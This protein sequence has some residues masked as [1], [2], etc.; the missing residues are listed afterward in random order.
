M[1]G[2]VF[3]CSFSGLN[4]KT[5]EVQADISAGLPSFKVVGL[6]DTSVQESKERV[7]T[8]IKNSGARF[9]QTRKTINLAP[10]QL[11]KQGSHFDLPMATALLLADNQIS[12]QNIT[13]SIV[14]GEL[15]LTG[16]VK[17]ISGALPITQ[18]AKEKGFTKIFLPK[19]NAE[20][21][22]FIE[23]IEIY[24]LETFKQL[25]EYALG[26]KDLK[27]IPHS[28]ITHSRTHRFSL[29]TNI[30]GLE[31]AKRGLLIAAAGGH[32]TLLHGSPGCGKTVICRAFRS[33]LTQMTKKEVLETTTIFSIGG[34]L[35]SE[36][37]I[38]K[39]RSFREVHHTAT[40]S[41][42]I[43]GGAKPRPGEIS[44]AHNG[45]LFLDEI[46]EFPKQILEALRQPLEDKH[47]NINRI[48]SSLKFPS[49]FILIATMN[50]CAC[51]YKGD[52][53]IPCICSEAH[54]KRYQKKISGPLRDRFDIFIEVAKTP[55]GKIFSDEQESK[56]D[57]HR[58]IEN[59]SKMQKQRFKGNPKTNKNSDMTLKEIKRACPLSK[60]SKLIL[61][62]A[63]KNLNLSN[64]GYLKTI[65]IARTIADLDQSERIQQHHIAEAIQF[66]SK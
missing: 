48:N 6:G 60:P 39:E 17:R 21:A 62:Q 61:N 52:K 57:Y 36:T 42:V 35:N 18:H 59:A 13:N 25:I 47:I 53:K 49:N 4:C 5:V 34:L 10:A 29:F 66:R 64:R 11:R 30:V 28:K 1:V 12:L 24:P 26:L 33:L 8:S 46:A 19:D 58:I 14:I 43:G 32:N 55:M 2:K 50:P 27:P 23:G 37:P 63:S 41:S 54:V 9:P 40:L 16:K 31:K 38:I 22:S 3:S 44:L 15:S 45:V 20:E 51:G 65:K 7:R 56:M